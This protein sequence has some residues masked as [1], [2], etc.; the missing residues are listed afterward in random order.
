M[1]P[2]ARGHTTYI[3]GADMADG[4]RWVGLDVHA[5]ESTIVAR[6]QNRRRTRSQPT[7]DKYQRTGLRST[8]IIAG[9]PLE[10]QWR[11]R[12][13]RSAAMCRHGTPGPEPS[14]VTTLRIPPNVPS[15]TGAVMAVA[16]LEAEVLSEPPPILCPR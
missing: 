5:H 16:D 15:R 4:I 11:R 9:A 6:D 10:F 8:V 14:R 2:S 7:S 12:R 3:G 1:T 13:S